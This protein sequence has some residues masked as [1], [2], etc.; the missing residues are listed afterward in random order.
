MVP[1]RPSAAAGPCA[2]PD[3]ILT[4]TP[5]EEYGAYDRFADRLAAAA[6]TGDF[7]GERALFRSQY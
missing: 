5:D 3:T 2:T 4:L 7:I 1:L 6:M